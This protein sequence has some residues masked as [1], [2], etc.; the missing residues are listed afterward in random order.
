MSSD[1]FAV[2][3][4]ATVPSK[5]AA[6]LEDRDGLADLLVGSSPVI[7]QLRALIRRIAPLDLSVLVCGPTGSGKE[8]VAAALHRASGRSGRFVSLN[9]CAVPDAMLEDTLFGHVRGAFTGATRDALGYLAEADGGTVFLDEVSGLPTH[10][11]VKLL[12]VIELRVFRPVGATRDRMSN[13]RVVAAT[14]EDLDLLIAERRFRAD[15][16]HRLRGIV[17]HVPPLVGHREDIGDLAQHFLAYHSM[18]GVPRSMTPGALRV[19]EEYDWPGNVRELRNVVARVCALAPDIAVAADDVVSALGGGA[20]ALVRLGGEG[21]INTGHLTWRQHLLATLDACA[22]DTA[23]VARRLSVDRSTVY[24]WLK[25]AGIPTPRRR[26]HGG[27]PRPAE[28]VD[29]QRPIGVLRT[30]R[31][32]LQ[33]EHEQRE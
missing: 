30:I 10:A 24:R 19:L 12:R 4:P 9:V 15:L 26:R 21:P 23:M 1:H 27:D 28:G 8:L 16:A 32:D 14:N 25:F 31:A 5:G 11:Q 6:D 17:V 20:R 7:R 29:G 13:F 33:L 3:S 18:N 2:P 22:G